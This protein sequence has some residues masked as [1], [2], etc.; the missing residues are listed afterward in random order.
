MVAQLDD[1]AGQPWRPLVVPRIP[2]GMIA[3]LRCPF[4]RGNCHGDGE[5][6]SC[7]MCGRQLRAT[8]DAP[9]G[10]PQVLGGTGPIP[11]RK[12]NDVAEVKRA[13]MNRARDDGSTGLQARLLRAI[14]EEPGRIGAWALAR[15]LRVSTSL[16][17]DLMDEL[18]DLGLVRAVE[19]QAGCVERRRP[20]RGY[21]RP[22]LEG[23]NES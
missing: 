6:I 20:T 9:R 5:E 11:I 12:S 22:R 8:T 19:Y 10:G 17:R 2:Y 13:A 14:P 3:G 16:V 1:G 21:Q 23:S 18:I 4:C 7:L 15:P